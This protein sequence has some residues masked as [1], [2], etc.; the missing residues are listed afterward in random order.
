MYREPPKEE[1]VKKKILLTR[2]EVRAIVLKHLMDTG[3]LSKEEEG[4]EKKYIVSM[5]CLANF[6]TMDK[7][8][9]FVGMPENT[10]WEEFPCMGISWDV[11]VKT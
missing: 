4:D 1:T 9:G 3:V 10:K 11:K 6:N 8:H 2:G 5:G 7:V